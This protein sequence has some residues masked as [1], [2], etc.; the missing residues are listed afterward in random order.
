MEPEFCSKIL[1]HVNLLLENIREINKCTTVVAKCWP[2]NSNI[3]MMFSAQSAPIV[4]HE[5]MTQRSVS[6]ELVGELENRCGSVVVN[7]CCRS[8]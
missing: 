5:T 8:W 1:W 2:V 7:C 6:D 4:T 3:G